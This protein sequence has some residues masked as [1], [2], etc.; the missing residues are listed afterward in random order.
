MQVDF[1]L[2]CR[3]YYYFFVTNNILLLSMAREFLFELQNFYLSGV[4][5][6]RLGYTLAAHLGILDMCL[7]AGCTKHIARGQEQGVWIA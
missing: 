5:L 7:I 4:A 1:I 6:V 3:K 2:N